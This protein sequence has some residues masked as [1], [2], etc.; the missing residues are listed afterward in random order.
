MG[1]E[2][3]EKIKTY[4]RNEG[5]GAAG[6]PQFSVRRGLKTGTMER[7]FVQERNFFISNAWIGLNFHR[8]DRTLEFGSRP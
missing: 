1:L 4:I 7:A 3:F 6:I 2:K 8:Q 5:M